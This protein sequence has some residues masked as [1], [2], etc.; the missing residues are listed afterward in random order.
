MYDYRAE[1]KIVDVCF[2]VYFL[3]VN[4]DHLFRQWTQ[5]C[6]NNAGSRTGDTHY[7]SKPCYSQYVNLDIISNTVTDCTKIK[8][9]WCFY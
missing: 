1:I 5:A 8:F 9:R 2:S 6:H 3:Q 7:I 4:R